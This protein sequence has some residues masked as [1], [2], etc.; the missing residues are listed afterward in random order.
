[1]PIELTGYGANVACKCRES[2]RGGG[3]PPAGHGRCRL[4]VR[5]ICGP[6]PLSSIPAAMASYWTESGRFRKSSS[7]IL[8]GA[9]RKAA[10][11]NR[12]LTLILNVTSILAFI[13]PCFRRSR[14]KRNE[15][16]RLRM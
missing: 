10:V 8:K 3:S 15:R 1:M 5:D 14:A 11:A 4:Q 2:G 7:A 6:T 12:N 13:E 9:S 16:G